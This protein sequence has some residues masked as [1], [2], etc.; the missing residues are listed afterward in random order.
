M[1]DPA[2]EAPKLL[3]EFT[4]KSR[5]DPPEDKPFFWTT[6]SLNDDFSAPSLSFLSLIFF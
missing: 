3:G 6:A 2:P 1:A 5:M 4:A